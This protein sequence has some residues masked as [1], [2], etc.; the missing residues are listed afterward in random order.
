VIDDYAQTAG[1]RRKQSRERSGKQQGDPV[2]ACEAI[3]KIAE[4]ENP[5]LRLVLGKPGYE[6]VLKKV[7]SMKQEFEAYRELSL[8]ADYPEGE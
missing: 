2:R 4:S 8:S 5:P 6:L 1:E 7:D 3:L